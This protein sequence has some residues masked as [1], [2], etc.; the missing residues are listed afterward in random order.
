MHDTTALIFNV[1]GGVLNTLMLFV[2]WRV[3]RPMPGPAWWF[4][5]AFLGLLGVPV[6]MAGLAWASGPLLFL[7]NFL[8]VA[9]VC[10]QYLGAVFYLGRR[11]PWR[12]LGLSFAALTLVLG[13]CTMVQPDAQL[14][15]GST[16]VY[17]AA[18]VLLMV[19]LLW[20]SRRGDRGAGQTF[21]CLSW[22]LFAPM[23]M[24]RG[25]LYLAGYGDTPDTTVADLLYLFVFYLS[26]LALGCGSA[27]FV[28]MTVQ[29]LMKEREHALAQA[30][31]MAE[32]YR[33]LATFDTLTG[34]YTRG[35]FL[36]LSREALEA[37]RA[38]GRPFHLLVFDLDHF[39]R[40][41]DTFGHAAG[42][43]A[44][45]ATAERVRHL[46]RPT[47]VL[48]RMGG[49]EFAVALPDTDRAAARAI[50]ER[51]KEAVAAQPVSGPHGR[52]RITFSGGLAAAG[53]DETLELLM[54]RADHALYAAKRAGR[55]RITT[56]LET[57]AA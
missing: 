10:V 12:R 20:A 38:G 23:L 48:G 46:L 53:A 40:V 13:W 52:F 41:N 17:E 22:G 24:V 11:P 43:D 14:R 30:Q 8:F 34:A 6:L 26:P 7:S 15:V 28:L 45:R 51:L 56:D 50:A 32:R 42:D 9:G 44:L 1:L 39:K 55:D 57:A 36:S 3:V 47:D 29:R 18:V 33:Q 25:F 49:E 21:A 2:A 31:G 16:S 19:R 27:G 54:D 4:S 5:G 37:A 35:P